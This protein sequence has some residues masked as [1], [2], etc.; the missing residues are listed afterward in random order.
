[1]INITFPDGS[2][3][4]Y[5]AGVTPL[6]IAKSISEKKTISVYA[7]E[8]DFIVAQDL[9]KKFL[10]I[11]IRCT[12]TLMPGTA[13]SFA[14]AQTPAS[15]ALFLSYYGNEPI[16]V[17]AARILK[18]KNVPIELITGPGNGNL[19][20]FASHICRVGYYEPQPKIASIG[21]R[22]AML[23]AADILYSYLFSLEFEKNM[24]TIRLNEELRRKSVN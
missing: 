17:Q 22:T 16:L 1:M 21:S 5:E 9:Q 12:A 10:N 4:Q 15:V 18:E 2:V 3:R 20:K 11:G 23:F 13:L 24:N 6:D 19:N 8:E 14:T 7:M